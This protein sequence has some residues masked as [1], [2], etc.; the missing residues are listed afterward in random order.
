MAHYALS[1]RTIL[2]STLILLAWVTNPV[3]SQTKI[4]AT[5]T[6]NTTG[7][8]ANLSVNNEG[9][10]SI[11]ILS[12]T[13][14]IPS[15][16]Q[17]QPY[18]ATIPETTVPPGT[19]FIPVNGYCVDIQAPPVPPGNLL[20]PMDTWV[21]VGNPNDLVPSG[22]VKAVPTIPVAPFATS[23]ISTITSSQHFKPGKPDAD[24]KI[25]WPGTDTPVGGIFGSGMETTYMAKVLAKVLEQTQDAGKLIQSNVNY[26]TPFSPNP[27]KE[28][29]SI[30]QQVI[31]IYTSA[32]K[33]KAYKKEKFSENVYH[34]FEDRTGTTVASLA[35][36]Q[37]NE[38]DKGIDQFWKVF[39]ATAVQAKVIS[40]NT[41]LSP[42]SNTANTAVSIAYPW[43]EISLI[44]ENMKPS[45][46]VPI[47]AVARS[48]SIIPIVAGVVG[49]GIIAYAVLAS[50]GDSDESCDFTI[51]LQ[52]TPTT[53]GQSNGR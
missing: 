49:V 8:V 41:A 20:P 34:Q 52:A 22:Y 39:T 44:G 16:G 4:T 13:V 36:D 48:S 19:T 51:A 35:A 6:G 7:H 15:A 26:G 42:S 43:S 5:G 50:G 28:R 29:E 18:I 31:W 23:D 25:N 14:Y 30:T 45:Y 40:T 37:K 53:C 24:I 9:T 38:I 1:Y 11:H 33:G 3:F 10:N 32:L 12:Q 27:E 47:V 46:V 17:Y 2:V 21:P